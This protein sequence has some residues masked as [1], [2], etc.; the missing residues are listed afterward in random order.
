M[1]DFLEKNPK[2]HSDAA[3]ATAARFYWGVSLRRV[4]TTP[5]TLLILTLDARAVALSDCA[6]A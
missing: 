1:D 3:L 5:Y 4:W 2:K 6:R